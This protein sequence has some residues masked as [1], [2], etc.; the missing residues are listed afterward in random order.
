[1]INVSHIVARMV[2]FISSF[3]AIAAFGQAEQPSGRFVPYWYV[4]EENK[5]LQ[6]VL[7]ETLGITTKSKPPLYGKYG[8]LNIIDKLNLVVTSRLKPK[9]GQ[10]IVVPV[11]YGKQKSL[12]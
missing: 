8:L 6:D 12:N 10:V 1:M 5:S 2:V 3:W 7:T 9:A 4:V 11:P